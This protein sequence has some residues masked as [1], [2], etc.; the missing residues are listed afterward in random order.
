MADQESTKMTQFTAIGLAEKTTKDLAKSPKGDR[1]LEILQM[2]EVQSCDKDIGLLFYEI[3]LSTLSEEK[4]KVIIPYIKDRRIKYYQLKFAIKYLEQGDDIAEFEKVSG[5]GITYTDQ[6][7]QDHAKA[8]AEESKESVK[9]SKQLYGSVMRDTIQKYPFTEGERIKKIVEL[10]IQSE[11]LYLDQQIEEKKVH[12][13][14]KK[15]CATLD[16]FT[17]EIDKSK[18]TPILLRDFDKK[19]GDLIVLTG[20]LSTVR[21]QKVSFVILRDGTG[22]IQCVIPGIFDITAES[23]VTLYGKVA[24]PPPEKHA[25]YSGREI[26]THRIEIIGMAAPDFHDKFSETSGPEVRFDQRHL[27]IRTEREATKQIIRSEILHCFRDH[28]RAGGYREIIPPTLV[29]TQCEGGATLFSLDYYGEKA[30][31]TQSSQLYLETVLPIMRSVYCIAQSYRAEK[32]K[33]R[34]HLSE[35]THIEAERAFISFEDL[36]QAIETLVIDVSQR[37]MTAMGDSILKIHPDF[38]VPKGPFK[39]M[40]YY[41]AIKFC[42][43]HDIKK[44][45]ATGADTSEGYEIGDDLPESA[46]R[47]MLDILK[48]PIFLIKFP[49]HIKS[50]Y[51]P[52]DPK[53]AYVTLSTDLLM[54]GV[55]EIVGGSMRISDYTELMEAYKREGLDADPYYWFTDQRKYGTCPHGGYG[56]GFDRFMTWILGEYSI[57]DVC[58]YPRYVGR[59]SP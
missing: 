8:K 56:L 12:I 25:P 21:S 39:R 45:D 6:E 10:V 55:G 28:Y 41:D 7:I 16:I 20:W 38:R 59:C 36:L 24:T 57:K 3:S 22:Y 58:L 54:P 32:S 53:D 34:R 5:V 1:L 9:S 26:Q 42:Q 27:V 4:L 43:E 31:L 47:A 29:Q 50:F 33:T 49:V 37:A 40:T 52:K 23:S 51:M 30:Y 48:E 44:K 17:T 11:Y 15:A 14:E 2:A 13:K 19:D 35:F 46:E 18:Y